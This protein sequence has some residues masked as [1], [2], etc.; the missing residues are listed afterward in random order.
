MIVYCC[1]LFLAGDRVLWQ[2]C[3]SC[4]LIYFFFPQSIVSKDGR[5][6]PILW[7]PSW[8]RA[9]R[10]VKRSF[11]FFLSYMIIFLKVRE[12]RLRLSCHHYCMKKTVFATANKRQCISGPQF[13]SSVP[14][15]R[16][17]KFHNLVTAAFW[18]HLVCP[19]VTNSKMR[20]ES[21]QTLS[22]ALP[23][24]QHSA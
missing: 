17:A 24:L 3:V 2:C 12:M 9:R 11:F 16:G 19:L 7:F 18:C 10:N 14:V 6:H 21:C 20:K 15:R 8:S 13:R 22:Q 1:S 5:E 4:F 23:A